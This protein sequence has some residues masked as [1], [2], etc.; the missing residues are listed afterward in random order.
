MTQPEEL[1]NDRP[2]L[3]STGTGTDV[4]KM[5]CAA[6]IGDRNE[7]QQLL[8]KDPSLVRCH[9]AYRTPLYFAVRENQIEIAAFIDS[10]AGRAFITRTLIGVGILA[11]DGL[12]QQ[13]RRSRFAGS[14]WPAE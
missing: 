3:W 1:K 9:Y 14:A 2:L 5:F 6:V 4:W 8:E 12:R 7:I 10:D 11:V 13:T